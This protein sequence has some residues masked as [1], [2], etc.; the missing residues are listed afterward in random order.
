MTTTA[1]NSQ[2][3]HTIAYGINV[4][5]RIEFA[6]TIVTGFKKL[7]TTKPQVYPITAPG[8]S[9]NNRPIPDQKGSAKA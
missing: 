3:T 7:T 6:A 1:P 2:P 9:D 4:L 5:E 8:Q